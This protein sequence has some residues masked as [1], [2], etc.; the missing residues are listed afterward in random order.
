MHVEPQ[1]NINTDH[2]LYFRYYS[3]IMN[4]VRIEFLRD[5]LSPTMLYHSGMSAMYSL[6]VLSPEKECEYGTLTQK[7]WIPH[8]ELELLVMEGQ[9]FITLKVWSLVEVGLNLEK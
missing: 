4:Q 6:A 8:C 2:Q 3:S 5:L 7:C 9:L 1:L